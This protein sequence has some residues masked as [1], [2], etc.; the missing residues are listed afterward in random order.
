MLGLAYKELDSSFTIVK[1]DKTPR[2]TFECDLI[3]LGNHIG[4]GFSKNN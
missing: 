4:L 1:I 3:F 2:E